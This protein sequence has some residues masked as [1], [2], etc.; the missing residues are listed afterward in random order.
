M[1]VDGPASGL[2]WRGW[3]ELVRLYAARERS[4]ARETTGRIDEALRAGERIAGDELEESWELGLGLDPI[5]RFLDRGDQDPVLCL[6]EQ[7]PIADAV[8]LQPCRWQHGRAR[9]SG[10]MEPD[11][12]TL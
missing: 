9:R 12:L 7:R 8:T 10:R 3:Q 1:E 5:D 2:E 11:R 4:P 6:D